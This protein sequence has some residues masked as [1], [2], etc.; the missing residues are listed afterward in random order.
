MRTGLL[1]CGLAGGNA[2][3]VSRAL[4]EFRSGQRPERYGLTSAPWFNPSAFPSASEIVLAGWD[5]RGPLSDHLSPGSFTRGLRSER[6]ATVGDEEVPASGESVADECE[7]ITGQVLDFQRRSGVEDVTVI[8]C[9]TPAP[10]VD[11][12]LLQLS[13]ADIAAQR[14]SALP[15]S[16]VYAFAA[17]RSGATY[18]DFTPSQTLEFASV[19]QSSVD[20]GVPV[21]GRDG[22]TGQT[23]LKNLVAS[24]LAAR[25]LTARSWYSANIL[26]NRDGLALSD[27]STAE[28]KMMDKAWGLSGISGLS[29]SEHLVDI[30]H[31][32]ALGDVKE[33]WDSATFEGFLGTSV[34]LRLNWRGEDSPL[35]AQMILDLCRLMPATREAHGGGLRSDLAFFFKRPLGV[36][37]ASPITHLGQLIRANPS[38]LSCS[39]AEAID[40]L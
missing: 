36:L 24:A 40:G 23:F 6:D 38:I 17:L 15:S 25:G 11:S 39:V 5:V 14:A 8:N 30:R 31:I 10:R 3:Q 9:S 16:L 18:I 28:T 7:R 37:P 19:L 27:P 2:V 4:N 12:E 20:L 13:A 34:E 35:A 29:S 1:L 32:P 33:A 21:A 26:G 22:A